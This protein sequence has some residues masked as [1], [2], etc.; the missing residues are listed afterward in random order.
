MVTAK[1][2]AGEAEFV[3]S[4]GFSPPTHVG[5]AG[6]NWSQRGGKQR[7]EDPENLKKKKQQIA[8]TQLAKARRSNEGKKRD[9]SKGPVDREE[10]RPSTGARA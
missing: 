5:K 2:R 10:V 3:H 8:R 7:K 6:K 4:N 1:K 9:A